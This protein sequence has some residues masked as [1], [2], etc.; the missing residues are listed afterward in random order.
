[1]LALEAGAAKGGD[2]RCGDRKASSAFLTV[3]KPGDDPINPYINLVVYGTD[4]KTKAVQA[5][6]QKL[7]AWRLK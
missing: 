5:L 4:E 2:K 1:M 6:R 7:N 3:A